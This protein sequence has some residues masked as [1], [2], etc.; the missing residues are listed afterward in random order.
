[1]GMKGNTSNR[2][3]AIV[4][5]GLFSALV[6]GATL[7]RVPMGRSYFHLGEAVIYATAV[8]FG[9]WYG[10]V[11]G[12]LGSAIADILS[13]YAFW[14]PITLV[15]KGIE[16]YVVGTIGHEATS[17]RS[18]LAM[19]TGA[20][21]LVAGYGIAAY[22]VLGVGGVPTE[23]IGDTIQGAAGIAFGMAASRLLLRATKQYRPH[24]D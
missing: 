14:A 6:L 24:E 23:L 7:I 2:V 9:R 18:F 11:A 21:I 22:F 12:A 16:G 1:M 10:G 3:R 19:L 15:V 8:V 13:G 5:G 17:L 20:V 4:L